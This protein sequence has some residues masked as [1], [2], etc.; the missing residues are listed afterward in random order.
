[1]MKSPLVFVFCLLLRC[2]RSFIVSPPPPPF[3]PRGDVLARTGAATPTA[4]AATATATAAEAAEAVVAPESLEGVTE[5]ACLDT[6]N[7]MRVVKVPVSAS[8]HPSGEVG[9]SYVNWPGERKA[10]LKTKLPP[11]VLIHGFD[12]S[13]L[14]YRRLGS[15]LAAR[16]IDTYAV[17]LLGWGFTQLD[18]V[19]S[20]SAQ[21]KIEALQ[22]FVE[23]AI[24]PNQPF[25]IAGASLGG[26]AAIEVAAAAANADNGNCQGL[27]LL[28]AQGFVDGIG[29][30][31]MMPKPVAKIGVEVLKSVP[32]RSS[33]NQM[34]Y[35]DKETYATDE[36]VVIGRMHCLRDGWSDALVS[37]MQSGGFS[38][39]SK[40]PTIAAP[41]LIL[42]GRQDGILDGE[43]FASKFVETLPDARLRWI[44]ECGHVPHLEKPDETADAIAEFMRDVVV[45]RGRGG[46]ASSN[47]ISTVGI[48]AK[49]VG[50]VGAA[51]ALA[52]AF[53][54]D[55]LP[56]H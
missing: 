24:G 43:E 31:Q 5:Q 15:R 7:R 13:C 14:E 44:E 54:A 56:V 1:M 36:A 28:D 42:W 8:V 45:S 51:T 20:F 11:M 9:I 18:G 29:P 34:S 19:A 26:A 3:R 41:S 22:S 12:S 35:F 25:C 46:V 23:T 53:G 2:G 10:A 30:M 52:A 49:L 47:P 39:S 33:A 48:D 32:L 16:G 6:A 50:I 27:V 21:S 4:A 40:L 17:C 38:P 55:F 37:F